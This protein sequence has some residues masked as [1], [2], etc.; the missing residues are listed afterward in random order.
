MKMATLS[1]RMTI[2]VF[3]AL[4]A[5]SLQNASPVWAADSC[6]LP[7]NDV[8]YQHQ[9]DSGAAW[10]FCWSIDK[11]Q[12]LLVKDVYYTAPGETQR[13]VLQQAS[14]AQILFKYDEDPVALHLASDP[15]LGGQQHLAPLASNCSDGQILQASINPNQVDSAAACVRI[16][17]IN[18]L[19]RVRNSLSQRRREISLHAWSRI[20]SHVYQVIWR[21]S[22]DGE[23][24]PEIAFGGRLNKQATDPQYASSIITPSQQTLQFANATLLYTWRL[25]FNINDTPDN[26]IVEEFEFPANV[27]DV[28]RRPLMVRR[29][30]TEALRDVDRES[31]RGWRIRDAAQ[32]SGPDNVNR[33]GYYLDP[34][35]AG[36]KYR[37]RR[38]NWT[39]FDLAVTRQRDCEQLAS[40]N[41]LV[42]TECGRS[43]D[44]YTDGESLENADPVIWFS[45][46]SHF[47]AS[48]EDYPAIRSRYTGFKVIPFD[49]SAHTPFTPPDQ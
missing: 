30:S 10:E 45:L 24:T 36:L 23:I 4:V 15:G 47:N 46:A 42:A 20:G 33:I 9:F 7:A 16:R 8:A 2:A 12:G 14:V 6:N 34:Q 19:T 48:A 49:W 3:L 26:D 18:N 28:V 43:L 44:Y 22:E 29:L 40:A 39:Q 25:D 38:H 1:Y 11:N 5:W 37:S 13:K 32:A 17:D 31:F 21:F 35:T 27:T 41:T